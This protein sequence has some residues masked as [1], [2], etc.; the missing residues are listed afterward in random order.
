MDFVPLW[1]QNLGLLI[2]LPLAV[3]AGYRVHDVVRAHEGPRADRGKSEWAAVVGTSMS[4]LALLL[5]F[6]LNMGVN[7]YE[8]R[9]QLVV[10]EAN[11]ISTTYL[12]SQLFD[13]PARGRL[14]SLLLKY[15][16]DRKLVFE[17][18]D[19]RRRIDEADKVTDNDER[20]LWAATSDALHQPADIVWVT[21][22]LQAMNSMFDLAA[23]RHASLEARIPPRVIDV[24]MLY[25]FLTAGMVGF[26][27][28]VAHN[29]R[30]VQSTLMFLMIGVTIG[31][32]KDLDHP[33]SGGVNVPEKPLES[34]TAAIAQAE[35]AKH[36]MAP[37]P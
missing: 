30:P 19:V 21:P 28:G 1:L 22:F 17:A 37:S 4:L 12:R 23:S 6:T 29:R 20:L 36:R 34:V 9:R 10:D 7:H 32:I 8:N 27:L 15:A 16:R 3:E 18:G 13:E 33:R 24:S 14:S 35:V 26:G 31:L 11:A 25:A 5:A 2:A